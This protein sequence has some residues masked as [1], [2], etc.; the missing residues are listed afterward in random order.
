MIS[1]PQSWCLFVNLPDNRIIS[2]SWGVGYFLAGLAGLALSRKWGY[3]GSRIHD[4]LL[5]LL[6]IAILLVTFSRASRSEDCY[7]FSGHKVVCSCPSSSEI[8]T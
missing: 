6:I 8:V 5:V 2:K 3:S 4:V 1:S 7:L